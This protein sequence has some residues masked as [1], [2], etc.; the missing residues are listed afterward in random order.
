MTS[1][2][3]LWA[4]FEL[5]ALCGF[6]IAQPLLD[7][8]GQSPD[9]FLFR[10][11]DRLDIVAL[12]LGLLLLPP[13]VM[14]GS[15]V[16]VGL[17]SERFRRYLHLALVAGLVTLVA[18]QVAKKLTGLRGPVVVAIA[19]VVGALAAVVHAR[20][21]WPRLWLRYLT[22]APLVF[23]LVFL[24]LSPSSRLVLPARAEAGAGPAPAAVGRQPPL[25]MILF[26][27]FPL[28][29]LLDHTGRIDRRVYPNFAALADQAT[30][31]RNA[32]GVAGYTP[33][34][35]PAML[36]GRY[37]AQAQAPSWTEYPDNML[38]LFGRYYDLKVYETI[39]QLCPP[40]RCRFTAGDPG[41]AGLGAVM[42]DSARVYREIV[43][44]YDV[45][46]DPASFIDQ[47]A[48]EETAPRTASR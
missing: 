1:R 23:A 48:A 47:T 13:L 38:T 16:V 20:A 12:V 26:D 3:R 39:S 18:I 45:A 44:P 42:G 37:P 25:V 17:V 21:S 9:V 8:T 14:W 43:S 46:V 4:F 41:R 36:T 22:P 24:L 15:E 2:P 30:W 33:W 29:S 34:A 10:R 28:S 32:T 11:A 31:Y 35:L 5:F 40:S 27:E 6:A 7:V 19:L